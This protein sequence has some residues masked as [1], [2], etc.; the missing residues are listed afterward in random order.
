[1]YE[2]NRKK[3]YY[4]FYKDCDNYI[5]YDSDD[6]TVKKLTRH[7]MY[8]G[9][10]KYYKMRKIDEEPTPNVLIEY[11]EKFLKWNDA[12]KNNPIFNV[13]W[14][15]YVNDNAA[16][17]CILY[18]CSGGK[19]KIMN[20]HGKIDAVEAN[21]IKSTF[22]TGIRNIDK[23]IIDKPTM[24]YSYDFRMCHPTAM[25]DRY[26]MIPTKKGEEKILNELPKN[27][28]E[29]VGFYRVN[30]NC[31]NEQF[32]KIFAFSK[33]NIYTER[34]L[35]RAL[36]YQNEFNVKIELIK[37]GKP[38]A[39]LYDKSCL[40]SGR[41]IFGPWFRKMIQMKKSPLFKGNLL[42]KFMS[43][44]LSGQLSKLKTIYKSYEQ[45][46]TEGLQIGMTYQAPYQIIDYYSDVDKYKLC[47]T[48]DM[49]YYNIARFKPFMISFIQGKTTNVV[50]KNMKD[51][52]RVYEDAITFTKPMKLSMKD[53]QFEEKTSGLIKYDSVT[54][55]NKEFSSYI[56]H[57]KK[58]D[59][60]FY[61]ELV[62][63][64]TRNF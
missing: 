36:K 49:F 28:M 48:D 54:T 62:K 12:L 20:M 31:N 44:S 21:W 39:Y 42:L 1:M 53:I 35:Y 4:L 11:N 46:I 14:L 2:E 17:V 56:E 16:C 7:E 58:Y 34:T 51:C 30:I 57:F 13:D 41:S 37:D 64:Y 18:K 50:T 61:N 25:S 63:K 27:L 38:N 47:K 5:C 10:H 60:K 19:N 59:E 26:L 40:V 9:T 52:V 23:R 22:G 32:L 3:P 43:S 45:V 6:K 24:L 29:N 33:D 8:D 55:R 15:D